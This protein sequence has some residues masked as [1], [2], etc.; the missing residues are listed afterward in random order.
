M[1]SN[2]G[3]TYT[4]CPIHCI[5]SSNPITL[6]DFDSQ[7]AHLEKN[8]IALKRRRNANLPIFR[9][10]PEILCKIFIFCT[11]ELDG[12]NPDNSDVVQATGDGSRPFLPQ[13]LRLTHICQDLREVLLQCPPYWGKLVPCS[14]DCMKEL[15]FRSS[16]APIKVDLSPPGPY[17]PREH[18]ENF[19]SIMKQIGRIHTLILP[20]HFSLME[21]MEAHLC[22]DAPTLEYLELSVRYTGIRL[23]FGRLFG[24]DTPSLRHINFRGIFMDWTA[25]IFRGLTSLTIN[26]VE[27][28][29]YSSNIEGDF[30]QMLSALENMPSLQTLS[31]TSALPPEHPNTST[32]RQISFPALTTLRVYDEVGQCAHFLDRLVLPNASS[33]AIHAF[34]AQQS[35]SDAVGYFFSALHARLRDPPISVPILALEFGVDS[36]LVA[37][38]TSITED[39]ETPSGGEELPQP[40]GV[41]ITLIMDPEVEP[42]EWVSDLLEMLP[43]S[44]VRATAIR[45][46]SSLT[47]EDGHQYFDG[48][49]DVRVCEVVGEIGP[50]FATLISTC[51]PHLER[52]CFRGI[53]FDYRDV[54]DE[55]E[56]PFREALAS[57]LGERFLN[58][59]DLL[60]E[61]E[62]ESCEGLTE[63]IIDR[64]EA[65]SRHVE[66][67]WCG[68]V[69]MTDDHS[70][71]ED[72]NSDA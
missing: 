10:P 41:A 16:S 68:F 67:D 66:W 20:L 19:S 17:R 42:Y 12:L 32:T 47:L 51:F 8:I 72:D 40:L 21:R 53:D 56:T 39:G 62:I 26:G 9:L 25:P 63:E 5:T 46:A 55:M 13:L 34:E 1:T 27:V 28:P 44:N 2:M 18:M 22:Q 60:E 69:E 6:V 31:L 3:L 57:S 7:I 58:G 43:L 37:A 35:H 50:A 52:L 4:S 71:T 11:T 23:P 29:N 33:I 38:Y 48:L 49:V 61:M 70:D 15:L 64:Y 24:G 54:D 14:K 30:S 45:G 59:F 36:S 65:Y